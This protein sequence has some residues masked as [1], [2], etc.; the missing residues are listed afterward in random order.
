MSRH[1]FTVIFYKV[2][3]QQVER[4]V[5]A[6]PYLWSEVHSPVKQEA[7]P[8]S[9]VLPTSSATQQHTPSLLLGYT[10]IVQTSFVCQI[11]TKP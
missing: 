9:I 7:A 11:M 4:L 10:Y 8:L 3:L 1:S 6:S 2:N 5:F